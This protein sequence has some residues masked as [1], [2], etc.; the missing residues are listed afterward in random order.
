MVTPGAVVRSEGFGDYFVVGVDGDA[1]AGDGGEP[2]YAR[3]GRNT[4]VEVAVDGGGK[5]MEDLQP[6]PRR[7]T[8]RDQNGMPDEAIT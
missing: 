6:E 5:G 3:I 4:R 1:G 7:A 8:D 2:V